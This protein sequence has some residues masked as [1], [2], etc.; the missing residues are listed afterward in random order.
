MAHAN[1]NYPLSQNINAKIK[2]SAL[3]LVV[4]SDSYLDSPWCLDELKWF[5]DHAASNDRIFVI[6]A[7][8]CR[9]VLECKSRPSEM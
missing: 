7:F 4:M 8:K 5:S 2:Q 9:R 3:L 6:K 1:G